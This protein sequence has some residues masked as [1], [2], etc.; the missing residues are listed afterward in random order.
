[1]IEWFKRQSLVHRGLAC[2]RTRRQ[3]ESA[4]LLAHLDSTPYIR[5]AILLLALAATLRVGLWQTPGEPGP[6]IA[7]S[8]L[9]F[10]IALLF[11]PL[12]VREVWR[13]NHLLTLT[14]GCFVVNLMI[15]KALHIAFATSP[16][17]GSNLADLIV[18]SAL[19]PMLVTILISSHAGVFLVLMQSLA[20]SLFVG[21]NLQILAASLLTGLTG[22]YFARSIRRRSDLLLAGAVVGFTG[23][24]CTLL[25]GGSAN[26][27]PTSLLYH[28]AWAVLSGVATAFVVSAVLPILEWM[29]DRI[30]DIS[31]LE[32]TDLNHALLRKL[33]LEA[34]GTYHHSLMVA[35]LAESAAEAIGA[36]PTACRVLAYFHDIG[37]LTKPA[38]FI[39]NSGVDLSPHK[40][41][42]PSMSALIIIAHVKEGVDLALKHNLPKPIL[43]TI[44]QHHGTSLVYYFYK[45]ALQQQ[46]DAKAGGKILKLREQDIP[47][48][49]PSS[50]RYPG[51]IPQFRECALISLADAVESSSR[52]LK[53]PTVQTIE[54]LVQDIIR[55]RIDDGQLD[56]SGLTLNEL[57]TI[58]ER[59]TFTLKNMLHARIEYPKDKRP[60]SADPDLDQQ[61]S[62]SGP[63]GSSPSAKTG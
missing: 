49:D 58:A 21:S 41:L 52:N 38:Y 6:V 30:T 48:V 1:M 23:L 35:N 62:K 15:N 51:P 39:E 26:L 19:G 10:G 11:M 40:D 60:D 28:G 53:N 37:K 32:L 24:L 29:F 18:P 13:S 45:K 16:Q 59:F 43:D 57:R 33:T 14:L 12:A 61:P 25:I 46:E 50:F 4:E 44:Q 17:A 31:W 9:L 34:P 63:T 36:N 27:S 2:D 7:L 54:T 20:D 5:W 22:V 8:V 3:A 47:D 42:T 55:Q 56:D